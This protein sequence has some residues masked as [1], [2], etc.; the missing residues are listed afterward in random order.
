M[1]TYELYDTKKKK[2][3][4]MWLSVSQYE[5]YL[6]DHPHV[7]RYFESAPGFVMEGYSIREGTA[8]IGGFKEVLQK[9]GEK[10]PGS[11]LEERYRARPRDTKRVK[12]DIAI[13]KALKKRNEVVA[14]RQK[15]AKW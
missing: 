12:T 4:E 6:K 9:I 15:R 8:K 1:P 5:Q 3:F 10:H 14:E 11:P 7:V 13:G 2:V